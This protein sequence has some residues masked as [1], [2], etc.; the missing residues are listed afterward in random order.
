MYYR[1]FES[2]EEAREA[3]EVLESVIAKKI[4]I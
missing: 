2:K 3:I 4:M 1:Q